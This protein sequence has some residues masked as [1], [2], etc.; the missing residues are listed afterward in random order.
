MVTSQREILITT[1]AKA[2]HFLFVNL[3]ITPEYRDK[4]GEERV[5][6]RDVS[7]KVVSGQVCTF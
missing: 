7:G 3:M 5:K 2:R 6:K 1:Q 4:V